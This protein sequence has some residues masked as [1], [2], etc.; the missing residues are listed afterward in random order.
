MIILVEKINLPAGRNK[1]FLLVQRQNMTHFILLYLCIL[2]FNSYKYTYSDT[3]HPS[4]DHF[5]TGNDI[6]RR[7]KNM[8]RRFLIWEEIVLFNGTIKHLQFGI[9]LL[10][11]ENNVWKIDISRL[12]KEKA[13]FERGPVW[14]KL[15]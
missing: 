8:L 11:I 4:I 13:I 12:K 9:M 14:T 1:A 2:R 6:F 5:T 7:E 15:N 10:L 3:K